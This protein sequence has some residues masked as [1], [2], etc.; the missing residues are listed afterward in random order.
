MI[1]GIA[2]GGIVPSSLLAYRM[3]C[4]LKLIQI[5]YRAVDNSP[6]RLAPE[7]MQTF[8]LP[9]GVKRILLV[10][11][12][13]VTGQTIETARKIL[14]DYDVISFVLKGKADYVVF[15]E[16]TECVIWPWKIA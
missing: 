15:P 5:N 3:G 14:K 12:V 13:S 10:D 4:S 11:D 7:V 2:N 9:A 1:V 6:Q 8:H 16:I